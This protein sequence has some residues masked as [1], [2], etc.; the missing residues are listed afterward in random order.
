MWLDLEGEG[1]VV[2]D[3]SPD[4]VAAQVDLAEAADT[5]NW[6]TFDLKSLGPML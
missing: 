4:V 3:G 2:A 1:R 6:Q 5:L